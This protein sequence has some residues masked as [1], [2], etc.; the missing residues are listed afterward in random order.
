MLQDINDTEVLIIINT[1]KEKDIMMEITVKNKPNNIMYL[2]FAMVAFGILGLE[3]G[4]LFISRIIDGRSFAQIGNWPIH[5][6]GAIAHW[7]I[8]IIVWLIGVYLIYLWAKKN[9]IIKDLIDF[10]LS[11]RIFYLV[12]IAI[13]VVIASAL[14]QMFVTDAQVP[15]VFSE[16]RGF[17]IMY[18][19]NAFIVTLFQVLYYFAEMLLVFIMIALFQRFGEKVFK[20]EYIPYGSI[21]LMLTW[22]MIHFISH[23][24]G[25]LGVTIWA[26]VP[27]L[28]YVY[29]KKSFLPVYLLLILGFIL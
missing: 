6:Y 5:W 7:V 11:N 10:E 21:G 22:G 3:F 19:D 23:P 17:E 27:G 28:L 18:G 14:V 4:V 24:A 1:I 2:V 15:Q 29:G 20:N 26:L 9:D 8:T 16:Y 13:L 12:I 25:A